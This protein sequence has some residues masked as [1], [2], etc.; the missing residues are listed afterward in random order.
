MAGKK[1]SIAG[2]PLDEAIGMLITEQMTPA[3][4]ELASKSA[5]VSGKETPSGVGG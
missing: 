4:V 5:R 2:L 1:Q 3:T